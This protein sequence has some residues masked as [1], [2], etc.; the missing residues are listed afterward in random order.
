VAACL[1]HIAQHRWPIRHEP[2]DPQVEQTLHLGGFVDCPDVHVDAAA[3]GSVDE[4]LVDH[5]EGPL[6]HG[7]LRGLTG[8][9]ARTSE[10]QGDHPGRAERAAE[11]I[12]Q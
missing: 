7:Y 5:G 8:E 4:R 3:V 9:R 6:A 11:P 12:A 10:A 1:E 2:V